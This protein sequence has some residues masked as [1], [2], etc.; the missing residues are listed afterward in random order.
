MGSASRIVA[1]FD[2]SAYLERYPRVAEAV[3]GGDFPSAWHHFILHGYLQNRIQAPAGLPGLV[4]RVLESG[5]RE[6]LPS[7]HL[8][9]RVH[10][11]EDAAA[12]EAVGSRVSFEL[13]RAL[14]AAGVELPAE[15]RI[16]DFGCGCGRILR[17]FRHLLDG[18]SIHGTDIDGEAVGWCREY[19]SHLGAFFTNGT[20]PPLDFP[21][22]A[23]DL[24]YSISIFTHLPEDMEL[25]WLAELGRVTRPGGWLVLT[26]TGPDFFRS[27][28][29]KRSARTLRAWLKR[30]RT[31]LNPESF[32]NPHTRFG[33]SRAREHL[34]KEGFYY[35][36]GS[37][38]EGLPKFYQGSFHT[39]EYIRRRWGEFFEVLSIVNN[40]IGGC[41]DLVLCRK[42]EASPSRSRLH[43]EHD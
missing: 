33:F 11:N 13:I 38:V 41:Q 19:L 42:R 21:D 1:A 25:A 36:L 40:G 26:V 28:Q 2:E 3:A 43:R 27:V 34:E 18:G 10:G 30:F 14:A 5:A 31:L 16:L 9:K 23:F 32:L 22:D 37:E 24:V 35:L 7:A 8:R 29:E 20:W 6:P 17:Y 15:A 4:G 39:W 12:F